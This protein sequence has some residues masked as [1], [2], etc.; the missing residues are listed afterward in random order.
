MSVPPPWEDP[1]VIIARD[2]LSQLDARRLVAE[3]NIYLSVDGPIIPT[4]CPTGWNP[5]VRDLLV[6]RTCGVCA[7]GA[8][9][10]AK[11]DRVDALRFSEMGGRLN[12]D[13]RMRTYLDEFDPVQLVLMELAFEG[14]WILEQLTGGRVDIS[15]VWDTCGVCEG[16]DDCSLCDDC[17]LL[18]EFQSALRFHEDYEAGDI[19]GRIE[20]RLRAIMQNVIANGGEFRP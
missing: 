12:D 9:F 17:E 14:G 4:G 15:D 10:V 7:I 11:V 18:P 6:G 3:V 1:R 13:G 16:P 20:R 2:V 5:E 19:D 8:L